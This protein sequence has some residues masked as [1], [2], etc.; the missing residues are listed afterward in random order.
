MTASSFRL[1]TPPGPRRVFGRAGQALH[2]ALLAVFRP[3][4]VRRLLM[5]QLALLMLMWVIGIVH[6]LNQGGRAFLLLQSKQIYPTILAIADDA[7]S[8]PERRRH[9]LDLL[10]SALVEDYPAAPERQPGI[11]VTRG[12]QVVYRSPNAPHVLPPDAGDG[13]VTLR[14]PAQRLHTRTV[15]GPD[16]LRVTMFAPDDGW[17]LLRAL[18]SDGF[19]VM[20][21]LTSL[22]LLVLPAWLSILLAMRPWTAVAREVARRGPQDLTPLAYRDGHRELV[23]MVDAINGWMRRVG[24]SAQRERSF[25][26]DAAHELRTPLAAMLV[27]VEALRAATRDERE[28]QLMTGVLSS[29][30]RATR[31]VNQLLTLMRSDAAAAEPA[32]PLEL[33]RLLQDRLAALEGLA[34][35]RRVELVL[36]AEA[37]LRLTGQRGAMESLVDNLVENAIKYGPP[38]GEVRVMLRREGGQAL[39]AVEDQGPGIPAALRERVFD[40]FFRDPV[41]REPGSGL[42]L[43]IA[44]SVVAGHGGRILLAEAVGSGGLRVEVRLPLR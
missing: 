27:N 34:T 14:T 5:A 38:G 20:P 12:T 42:G 29:G 22:P 21:L 13:L 9:A 40:R 23:L 8:T 41:Q 19:Y 18:Y 4:L 35:A 30:H 44:R 16:G 32:A 3:S 15:A 39:L 2:E 36:S 25:I 11:L 37:G 43:S 24:D 6:L 33:D 10:H 28:R 1:P 31:L 26:A 7:G 17:N